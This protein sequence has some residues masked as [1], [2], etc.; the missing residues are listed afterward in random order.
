[1]VAVSVLV[2]CAGEQPSGTDMGSPKPSFYLASESTTCGGSGTNNSNFNG[3]DRTCLTNG[4]IQLTLTGSGEAALESAIEAWNTH[5]REG[6]G[7]PEM[8]I[9]ES[10]GIPVTIPSS[11]TAYCGG[12]VP[13]DSG[14][15]GAV[16]IY[17]ASSGS[18]SSK[19]TGQLQPVL[20]HELAHVLGWNSAH[21][22][23]PGSRT[24]TTENCVTF[25]PAKE[26]AEE[27][28]ANVCYH[29]VEALFRAKASE[30]GW[31][32][33]EDYF[34]SPILWTTNAPSSES[35]PATTSEQISMSQWYASPSGQQSRSH[36]H[37]TWAESSPLFSVDGTGTV[38]AGSTEGSGMLYLKATSTPPSGYLIW[39]PFKDRGDSVT[40]VVTEAPPPPPFLIDSVTADQQPVIHG[41]MRTF[42]VH[43]SNPP[44]SPVTTTW[45]VD[46]PRT[47]GV[48]PDTTF[49]KSTTWAEFAV[50]EGEYGLEIRVRAWVGATGSGVGP[51][52]FFFPV[53]PGGESF[54]ECPSM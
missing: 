25:L 24:S 11:D 36:S 42:T 47:T 5:L 16:I 37:L 31:T 52:T 20:R 38:I 9:V 27:M 53:C 44:G 35:V 12:T 21:G 39:S 46:D 41:G 34:T 1:M 48:T 50:G 33:D 7:M 26:S 30:S 45:W 2:A 40:I 18:C 49:S 19:K 8:D 4:T 43:V 32:Y 51:S 15:V 28:T 29:D 14:R 10:G 6:V 23:L 3:I 13:G 54:A 17:R 22:G